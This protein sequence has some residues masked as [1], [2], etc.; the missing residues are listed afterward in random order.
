MEKK[1]NPA[2]YFLQIMYA[3][4][5]AYWIAGIFALFAMNYKRYF[6]S[7]II[8]AFMKPVDAPIVALGP[9]LQIFRGL[10]IAL[11]LLPLRKVFF[12]E[13]YGLIKL[14]ITVFGFSYLSTIGPGIGSFE[15]YIYTIIPWTYQ[16]VG[17][18][19][20]VVY[21]LLFIGILHISIKYEQRKIISILSIVF[22]AVIIFLGI[23]GYISAYY[24][25]QV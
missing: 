18:P 3:H 2:K 12:D 1:N 16:I 14:G 25:L 15:G 9:V 22:M 6:S 13:K 4:T 23:M 19:E 7:E 11:I 17:L 8:S 5:I 10:L 20:T 21:I 24:A